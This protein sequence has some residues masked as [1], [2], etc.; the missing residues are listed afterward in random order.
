[1]QTVPQ[2]S[3]YSSHSSMPQKRYLPL[4]LPQRLAPSRITEEV[5]TPLDLSCL[6]LE[7]ADLI[8]LRR[9]LLASASANPIHAAVAAPRADWGRCAQCLRCHDPSRRCRCCACGNLHHIGV[10]C[11]GVDDSAQRCVTCNH[12]H[13]L[14]PCIPNGHVAALCAQCGRNHLPAVR[15]KCRTCH[16]THHTSSPCAPVSAS[17]IDHIYAGAAFDRGPVTAFDNGSPTDE[18][19]YCGAMFFAGEAQYVNCCRKGT[20]VVHHP[21]IPSELFSLITDSHVQTHIRQY[22][23]AVAMASVGY[24]GD[25]MGRVNAHAPGRP[26]VDGYGDCCE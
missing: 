2:S 11:V 16:R 3:C 13:V 9:S 18:C 24:S 26:H 21:A 19:P 4:P 22:N 1:M 7:P 5:N 20:I 12:Y 25:A 17:S 10:H 14:G 15:C 6:E 8:A 23:A